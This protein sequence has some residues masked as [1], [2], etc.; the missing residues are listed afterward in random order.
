VVLGVLLG[1]KAMDIEQRLLLRAG[2]GVV[3]RGE[4][5]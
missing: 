4:P 1:K 5:Q 2:G 3:P